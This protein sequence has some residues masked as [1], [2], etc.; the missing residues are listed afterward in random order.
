MDIEKIQHIVKYIEENY[1]RTILIEE[2]ED[3]GCYSYRNL[4]RVFQNLFKETLGAFQKRL[5][6]ENGYKKLIYTKDTVTDIAY[7]VGF[8]SLQAFTK[9]FKKQFG[10]AP[11]DARINR[12]H[13]FDEYL[14]QSTQNTTISYDIV[15]LNPVKIF[16]QS[17]KTSNYDNGEI[18]KLWEKI[19]LHYGKQQDLNYYGIIVD[20]PLITVEDHCRY[21]ACLNQNPNDKA[22]DTKEIFGGKYAKYIHK[23]NYDDI[24][25]TY[26]L[27]YKDWLFCS[28][29]EF[30]TSP[31]IEHYVIHNFSIENDD[32]LLT[33]ILIPLKKK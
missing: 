26:R 18:D 13:I 11:S 16:Y 4:H 5:K 12:H 2:L 10:I 32:S 8:E 30:D 29:L 19:D 25:N 24:E 9:S 27:I 21:E 3:I 15:Y 33:E 28:K 7:H 23:G 6:L 1:A 17:I 14:R 31:I 22:F 20:Q